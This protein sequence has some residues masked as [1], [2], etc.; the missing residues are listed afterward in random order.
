MTQK[1][2]AN[3]SGRRRPCPAMLR[4][5]RCKSKAA[6]KGYGSVILRPKCAIAGQTVKSTAMAVRVAEEI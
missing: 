1:R 5:L 3:A 4:A 2:K 6:Q